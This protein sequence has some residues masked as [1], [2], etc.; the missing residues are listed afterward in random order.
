MF[1]GIKLS[2]STAKPV[3]QG[4]GVLLPVVTS[5]CDF[6]GGGWG[7]G[8]VS[9]WGSVFGCFASLPDTLTFHDPIPVLIVALHG[10]TTTAVGDHRAHL[11]HGHNILQKHIEYNNSLRC[12]AS[13]PDF[14]ISPT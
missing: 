11:F 2:M 10:Y 1:A 7:V 13:K 6:G 3:G 5:L 14:E 4:Y 12:K 9:G 8:G